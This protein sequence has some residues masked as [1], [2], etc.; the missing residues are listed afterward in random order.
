MAVAVVMDFE[1]SLDQYDEVVG[2]MGL[3]PGG[4]TPPGALFHWVTATENG[5][6]VTDVWES[7]DV[8]QA[9]A[10]EHIGPNAA[11]AGLAPPNPTF[12]EVYN[13]FIKQ[14]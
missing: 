6:R 10:E 5:F 11:E 12:H 1:G 3:T 13:H 8:F 4:P 2:K 9:F 7:Q 14:G